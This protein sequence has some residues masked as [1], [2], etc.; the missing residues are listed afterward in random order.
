MAAVHQLFYPARN[1]AST[2]RVGELRFT[3]PVGSE[4]IALW[5]LSPEGRRVS[6]GF[7][8]LALLG[9]CLPDQSE[10]RQGSRCRS[11]FTEAD[12]WGRGGWGQLAGL[13]LVIMAGV[14]PFYLFIGIFSPTPLPCCS[15]PGEGV[16]V[17]LLNKVS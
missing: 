9:P 13:C 12:V 17:G 4:E 5:S 6:K 3:M 14:S 1:K 16:G 10:V 2:Q 11:K 8:G 7:Y 15:L